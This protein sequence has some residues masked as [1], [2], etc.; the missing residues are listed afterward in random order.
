M[1][2]TSYSF[3][4]ENDSKFYVEY[5]TNSKLEILH[6]YIFDFACGKFNILDKLVTNTQKKSRLQKRPFLEILQCFVTF[7]IHDRESNNHVKKQMNHKD[8][9]TQN[10]VL[11]HIV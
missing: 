9:F 8:S 5:K 3:N 2:K 10:T 11:V 7:F 1:L 4:S 6:A